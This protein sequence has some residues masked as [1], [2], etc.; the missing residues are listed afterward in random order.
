MLER[1]AHVETD[2]LPVP[3][4]FEKA[5][6]GAARTRSFL[7]V[8]GPFGPFTRQ[9]AR[10]LRRHGAACARVILNGGDLLDWGAAFADHFRGSPGQWGDWLEAVMRRRGVT[11]LI[12]Y[13]DSNPYAVDAIALAQ[14]AGVRV[15]VL[16]QGYLRPD[17][18]TLER[19]GVNAN[20][21]LPRSAQAFRELAAEAAEAA[22]V[23]VGPITP[24]A[25]QRIVAHHVFQYLFAPLYPNYRNAYETS[26][27]RQAAGHIRRYVRQRATR[28]RELRRLEQILTGPGPVYLGLL[29]RPGDSQLLRHSTLRTND[30]FMRVVVESFARC[31]PDSARLVFKLHPLDPGVDD[32]ERLVAG[33]ASR[34]GCAAR[35]HVVDTGKLGPIL[36]RVAGV[37]TN[38]STGGLSAVE[39]G[40]PTVVLGR[41]IYDLP[42][43]T[44]QGGLDGFWR[45]PESPDP[46]LY[47][48]FRRV[49]LA[50]TQINGGYGAIAAAR[51]AAPE[52]ARRLLAN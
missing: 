23:P 32:Y 11:D 28:T 42:G 20:S 5:S 19:D 14:R 22:H 49:V 52:A 2:A 37:V 51:L 43:L 4:P 40:R 31:A 38:N 27:P 26:A 25:V 30:Q 8:L 3:A 33:A 36:P 35:V 21:R 13:G 15:H 47:A 39:F 34:V 12:T 9:V 50:R 46:D 29:Q 1:T 45:E 7:F 10:E 17:W 6:R 44:H 16:E 41:A 24:P 18:I 48:C